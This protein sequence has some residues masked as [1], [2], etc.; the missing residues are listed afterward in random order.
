MVMSKNLLLLILTSFSTHAR[1]LWTHA[2]HA[3]HGNILNQSIFLTHAKILCQRHPRQNLIHATH[4]TNA[5]TLTTPP[6][7]PWKLVVTHET[8]L[9][10]HVINNI[11]LKIFVL[12]NHE[13]SLSNGLLCYFYPIGLVK[14][15]LF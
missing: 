13:V 10:L 15:K 7:L 9:R 12:N 5:P 2:I 6:I 3:I 11:L 8:G 4:E 14:I 1:V